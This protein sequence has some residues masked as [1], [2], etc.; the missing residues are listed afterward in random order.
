MREGGR[1]VGGA[2]VCTS[3][4][5]ISSSLHCSLVALSQMMPAAILRSEGEES[6]TCT[7]C[8]E[9]GVVVGVVIP[10]SVCMGMVMR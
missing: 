9:V 10:S 2:V 1:E 4:P 5:D 6:R 3:A 8:S 7:Y